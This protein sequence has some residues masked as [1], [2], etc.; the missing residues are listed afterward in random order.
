MVVLI[1]PI[2]TYQLTARLAERL[3]MIRVHSWFNQFRSVD[4]PPNPH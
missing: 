1:K 2:R 4:N 3:C